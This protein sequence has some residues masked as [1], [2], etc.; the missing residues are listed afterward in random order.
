MKLKKPVI[1]KSQAKV[2]VPAQMPMQPQGQQM[3]KKGGV[4]KAN[5]KKKSM[6]SKKGC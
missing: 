6:K 4:I 3:M 1:K 2:G 5:S